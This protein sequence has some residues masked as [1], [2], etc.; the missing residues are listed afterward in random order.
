ML[1]LAADAIFS[2]A[3]SNTGD[4]KVNKSSLPT[5]NLVTLMAVGAPILLITFALVF[6]PAMATED[7]LRC[8]PTAPMGNRFYMYNY[9]WEN[10]VHHELNYTNG[11]YVEGETEWLIH[12][13]AFPYAFFCMAFILAL[14]TIW[15]TLTESDRVKRQATYIMSGIEEGLSMTISVMS[16]M[17]EDEG[18]RHEEKT[19]ENAVRRMEDVMA[20]RHGEEIKLKFDAFTAFLKK[21]A[22][23]KKLARGFIYRRVLTSILV[24]FA[25]S[26]RLHGTVTPA[27]LLNYI[28]YLCIKEK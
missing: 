3:K 28:P 15:W 14:P 4:L 10:F 8:A 12:H 20:K 18:R 13:K 19:E 2:K 26:P 6:S 9:C 1:T 24:K 25:Y 16:T 5:D 11:K 27:C 23:G 22:N 7:G 21:K 17:V